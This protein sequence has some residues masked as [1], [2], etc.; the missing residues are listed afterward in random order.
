MTNLQIIK[1]LYEAFAA[2]DRDRILEIFDPQ[3]TWVQNEGFPS[4]G[5][6]IG[7]EV[8]L[9]KVFAPFRRDWDNWKAI[10]RRW[11]DAGEAI[12]A[13]GEYKGTYKA[14]HRSMTAVFAHVY[15]LRNDRIVRFEQYTDT[16]K[17]AEAM[18]TTEDAQ[19]TAQPLSGSETP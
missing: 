16:I 17:V 10:V 11:L 3:I 4:G 1:T 2:R 6:H 12:V 14:T 15:W 7:A 8:V 18:R 13:L 5:T 9:D 19:G